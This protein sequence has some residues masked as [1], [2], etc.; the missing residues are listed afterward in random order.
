MAKEQT[1]DEFGQSEMSAIG[2]P[3]QIEGLIFK[4]NGV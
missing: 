4:K 1:I 3:N 2:E